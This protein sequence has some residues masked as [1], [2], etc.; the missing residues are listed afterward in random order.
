MTHVHAWHTHINATHTCRT[1]MEA[2]QVTHSCVCVCVCVSHQD[3]HVRCGERIL[4]C[5]NDRSLLQKSP[6]KET[7]FCKRDAQSA[8]CASCL[9]LPVCTCK[10]SDIC[11]EP[12]ALTHTATHCNALQRTATH[13]R[14]NVGMNRETFV[15]TPSLS[16]VSHSEPIVYC[17]R[18]LQD[19][20]AAT[21]Y[22][23]HVLLQH[24]ATPFNTL[25]RTATHCNALQHTTI[26]MSFCN[27]LQHPSTH[28]NALQHTA[29]HCNTPRY[30]CLSATPCNSL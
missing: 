10:Q 3:T 20:L 25:Q 9:V 13:Q 28:C 29:T 21:H 12:L 26:L 8:H 22:D 11:A 30:S 16:S 18:C 1:Y 15:P 23:T 4:Y 7:I 5:K 17:L 6:I 2:M 14:Y 19:W 27:T 24:P